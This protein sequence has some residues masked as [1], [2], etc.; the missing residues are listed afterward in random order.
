MATTRQSGFFI[1]SSAGNRGNFEVVISDVGDGRPKR[2]PLPAP[3]ELIPRTGDMVVETFGGIANSVFT[4]LTGSRPRDSDNLQPIVRENG[5]GLLHFYRDNDQDEPDK[6]WHGPTHFGSG[7]VRSASLIQG[8]DNYLYVI[9]R[10]YGSLVYYYTPLGLNGWVKGHAA[11]PQDVDLTGNPAF[12][13]STYGTAGHFEV[14][15]AKAGGGM[16]HYRLDNDNPAADWVKVKD[17]G[18]GEMI[19]AVSMI[20]GNFGS[21]GSLELVARAGDTLTHYWYDGD[22]HKGGGPFALGVDGEPSLIQSSF[23][24][25]GN[26]EVVVPRAAGGLVH[27]W[28]NN[29]DPGLPWS[30]PTLISGSEGDDFWETSLIQSSYGVLEVVSRIRGYVRLAHFWGGGGSWTRTENNLPQLGD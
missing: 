6:N 23:G 9:T 8:N 22:W 17:F 19:E 1:Q 7:D 28:R 24:S 20:Q 5:D 10:L 27:Y 26:F 14:V 4:D 18:D 29:D 12:L 30:D 11:F 16:V 21:P 3:P 15:A 25:R 2:K 13:Q